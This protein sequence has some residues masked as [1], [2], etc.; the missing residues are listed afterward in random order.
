M[1]AVFEPG[2]LQFYTFFCLIL[3]ILFVSRNLTS[4]H[5]PLSGSLDSLLCDL[6]APTPG[7]AFFLVMPRTLAAVSS[8]SSSKAYPSLNFLP[9][10][11]LCLTPTLIMYYRGQH[12]SNKTP[13][14]SHSLMSML[15]LFV[16]LLRIAK[17]TPF[18]PSSLPPSKISSFWGTSIAITPSGAQEVFPTTVRKKY[19]IGS[20]LLTSSPSMIL[21]CL[22]FCI[23][24]L[25]V[26]LLLKSPLL[27]LL[28]LFL[29]H[30]RC[31]RI[32]VLI[33][34]QFF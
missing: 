22:L 31:F 20:S 4:I 27:S 30:G 34:Y 3:L 25:A 9:L 24:H 19:S 12:L 17:P 29:A 10:F 18:L 28:S 21:T 8:F 33:I 15:P 32:W 5:S 13:S 1:L 16:F 6:I 2:A 14:R 23:A 26:A 7:L 11:F